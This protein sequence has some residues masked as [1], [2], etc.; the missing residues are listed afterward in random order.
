MPEQNTLTENTVSPP[1]SRSYED[2]D[3]LLRRLAGK[4][5]NVLDGNNIVD[6]IGAAV[7]FIVAQVDAVN[8]P[9]LTTWAAGK[10]TQ[11][12]SLLGADVPAEPAFPTPDL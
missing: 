1:P 7:V 5:S 6:S 8:D 2:R 4:V 10:L 12:A 9:V 11:V 3:A